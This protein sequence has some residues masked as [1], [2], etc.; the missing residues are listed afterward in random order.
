MNEGSLEDICL[1]QVFLFVH[2][3]LDDCTSEALS[4][5]SYLEERRFAS[6]ICP[7]SEPCVCQWWDIVWETRKCR[8]RLQFPGSRLVS[9]PVPTSSHPE[10][11]ALSSYQDNE[12]KQASVK[13]WKSHFWTFNRKYCCL[14]TLVTR[15]NDVPLNTCKWMTKRLIYYYV[16]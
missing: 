1:I 2:M 12:L 3:V 10:R 4:D 9:H 5:C 15:L 14:L 13:V 11:R 6:N 7:S 8:I 16:L